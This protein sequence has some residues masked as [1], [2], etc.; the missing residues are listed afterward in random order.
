VLE[1]WARLPDSMSTFNFY[2]RFDPKI[3]G[4]WS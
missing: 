4:Y 2:A 1:C 3:F